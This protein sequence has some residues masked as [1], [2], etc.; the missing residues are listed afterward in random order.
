MHHQRRRLVE[1]QVAEVRL[2]IDQHVAACGQAGPAEPDALPLRDRVAPAEVVVPGLHADIPEGGAAIAQTDRPGAVDVVE[3]LVVVED[4][5]RRHLAV[6]RRQ[7]PATLE[8]ELVVL[9]DPDDGRCEVDGPRRRPGRPPDLLQPVRHRIVAPLL[10]DEV[11]V[12]DGEV[13]AAL[14]PAEHRGE[15]RLIAVARLPVAAGVLEPEVEQ[16]LGIVRRVA[17]GLGRRQRGE[18][19]GQLPTRPGLRGPG[20][21]LVEVGRVGPQPGQMRP[22]GVV[23]VDRRRNRGRCPVELAGG[24]AEPHAELPRAVGARP[25]AHFRGAGAAE[26]RAVRNL[27]RQRRQRRRAE[28]RRPREA[29][30]ARVP[31]HRDP[32]AAASAASSARDPARMFVSP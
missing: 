31:T 21:H 16:P 1:T 7:V 12:Q 30:G 10:V 2:G 9:P 15:R 11:A 25:D 32:D 23:V 5:E 8:V 28:Q 14:Q 22:A 18:R 3:D 13:D 26:D 19:P 29:G 24:G 4:E 17:V 27:L 20:H 6:P